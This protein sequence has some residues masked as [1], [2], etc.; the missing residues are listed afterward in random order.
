MCYN[1]GEPRG[2]HTKRHSSHNKTN[3]VCSL[4]Q[5][6]AVKTTRDNS[7]RVA[8]R[9]GRGRPRELLGNGQR[10]WLYKV[11]MVMEKDGGNGVFL[12]SSILPSTLQ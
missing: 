5:S 1:T 6:R 9:A 8:A 12:M 3:I 11:K 4:R 10:V 7:R 2:H